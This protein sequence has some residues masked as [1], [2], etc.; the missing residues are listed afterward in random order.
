MGVVQADTPGGQGSQ[1]GLYPLPCS[2]ADEKGPL[3]VSTLGG[4]AL[5]RCA[6]RPWRRGWVSGTTPFRQ[7][8]DEAESGG[9]G[10]G[11]ASGAGLAAARAGR[12]VT[13]PVSAWAKVAAM[14]SALVATSFNCPSV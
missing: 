12:V 14:L 9:H 2:T 1:S 5:R 4:I 3:I 8:A 6:E 7:I 11:E 10:A 13:V